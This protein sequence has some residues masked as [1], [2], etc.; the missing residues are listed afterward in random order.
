MPRPPSV[1][2]KPELAQSLTGRGRPGNVAKVAPHHEESRD[3]PA[4]GSSDKSV[5]SKSSRLCALLDLVVACRR[6]WPKT[7]RA[8][9]VHVG[10][11]STGLPKLEVLAPI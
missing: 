6:P 4:G 2:S 10:R 8:A 1:N 11:I 3:R 9:E 7:A 5:F